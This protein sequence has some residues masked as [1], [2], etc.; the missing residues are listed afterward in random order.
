M[1]L[2]DSLL[3][4]EALPRLLVQLDGGGHTLRLAT[5]ANL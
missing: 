1:T 2:A 3:I 5:E 4:A